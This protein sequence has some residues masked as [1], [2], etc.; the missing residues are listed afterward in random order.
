V[1]LDMLRSQGSRR[2]EHLGVHVP[3][4]IVD[5]ADGTDPEHEALLADSVG[6][7]PFTSW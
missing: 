2:E 5:R 3:E 1:S 7:A 4:P 6:L